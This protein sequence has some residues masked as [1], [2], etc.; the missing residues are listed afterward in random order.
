MNY[1]SKVQE[2]LTFLETQVELP[3]EVCNKNLLD[4]ADYQISACLEEEQ[5]FIINEYQLQ[6]LFETPPHL[7]ELTQRFAKIL[8]RITYTYDYEK[9]PQKIQN[10]D[11]LKLNISFNCYN[12]RVKGIPSSQGLIRIS[13][14]N[15][16][17]HM[18][19]LNLHDPL[20]KTMFEPSP[21]K[22][23]LSTT[24]YTLYLAGLGYGYRYPILESIMKNQVPAS[25]VYFKE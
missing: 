24:I 2:A 15:L 8:A 7:I 4:F 9:N 13:K 14:K 21:P 12:A 16:E 17:K 20:L 6:L 23:H 25:I 5:Y 19:Y 11:I 1:N 3:K 22:K 10:E 18:D